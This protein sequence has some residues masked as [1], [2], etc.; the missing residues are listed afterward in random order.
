MDSDIFFDPWLSAIT[1]QELGPRVEL[2]FDAGIR[3][4][5]QRFWT[6]PQRASALGTLP[7]FDSLVHQCLRTCALSTSCL[8]AVWAGL[9]RI[10]AEPQ[11]HTVMAD[12]QAF[13]LRNGLGPIVRASLGILAHDD[14]AALGYYSGMREED[15]LQGRLHR[16]WVEGTLSEEL[17]LMLAVQSAELEL[18]GGVRYVSLT[19][20][21]RQRGAELREQLLA[22]GYL[23]R[24]V[25]ALYIAHFD[26][27]T[28]DYDRLFD[29]IIPSVPA[30]RS[31]LLEVFSPASA[32]R[33][34]EIGSGTGIFTFETGLAQAIGPRGEISALEPAQEMMAVARLRAQRHGVKN[35]RFVQGRAEAIPFEDG[36]FDG[37]VGSLVLHFTDAEQTFR[38]CS[39]ILRPA[40]QM[41]MLWMFA[42]DIRES[43]AFLEWM[44]PLEALMQRPQESGFSSRRFLTEERAR[45]LAQDAGFTDIRTEK[46]ALRHELW[47]VEDLVRAMLTLSLYQQEFQQL[48]FAARQDLIRELIARGERIVQRY[49]REALEIINYAGF[50]SA[51]RPGE[52]G[53][54]PR[55]PISLARRRGQK[56]SQGTGA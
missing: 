55:P 24:R 42:W 14:I 51:K 52:P 37:V 13:A 31:R 21:G 41:A 6:E 44:Q 18:R 35:V 46:M 47:H 9:P 16:P 1:E 30:A 10:P 27:H 48:P 54:Q 28:A 56:I 23:K 29:R 3:D 25:Q 4:L 19:P 17:S 32:S 39:R 7:V 34:L 38:E 22:A 12:L 2:L 43:E 50:I 40:G 36:L 33:V 26:M 20:Y 53:S 15:F 11:V 45:D 8:R 5:Q 49:P